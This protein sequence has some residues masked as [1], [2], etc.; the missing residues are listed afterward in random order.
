MSQP[1]SVPIQRRV[2]IDLLGRDVQINGLSDQDG[3]LA[4]NRT[5]VQGAS[6]AV[7]PWFS[8]SEFTKFP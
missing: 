8:V 3:Q 1:Q 4:D 6:R 2:R 5:Q 7:R